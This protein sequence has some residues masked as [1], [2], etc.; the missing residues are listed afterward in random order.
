MPPEDHSDIDPAL[1]AAVQRAYVR[2]VDDERAARHVA[3]VAATA[4]E[5]QTAPPR[6]RP[7]RRA[8]RPVVALGLAV[9]LFPA[10]LAAAGVG[11]PSAV[12]APY[13]AV[14]VDL[15]NQDDGTTAPATPQRPPRTGAPAPSTA[16]TPARVVPPVT[17]PAGRPTPERAQ[18]RLERNRRRQ[19]E[20][21][22]E[23]AQRKAQRDQRKAQRQATKPGRRRGQTG[24]TPSAK[25][26]TPSAKPT[27]PV[28]RGQ[29]NAPTRKRPAK[30]APKPKRTTPSPPGSPPGQADKDTTT[31]PRGQAKKQP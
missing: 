27:P 12:D 20:R 28:R 13:R 4:R 30:P 31:T 23:R 22:R 19:A 16:T 29:Q 9:L 8:W 26:P 14:G 3:A 10:A 11:L 18:R 1:S 2:P 6:R 15:P 17:T 7:R 24:V 25:R 21:R 5:V